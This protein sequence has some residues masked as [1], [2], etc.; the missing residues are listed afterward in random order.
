[1]LEADGGKAFC[2]GG[3]VRGNSCSAYMRGHSDFNPGE[4]GRGG[5]GS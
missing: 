1:M 2:A 5:R 3:D 4:G